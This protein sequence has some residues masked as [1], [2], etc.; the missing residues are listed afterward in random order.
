M[1]SLREA[2]FEVYLPIYRKL[3]LRHGN[4]VQIKAPLFP[5]YVFIKDHGR[6]A[7]PFSASRTTGVTS[8]AARTLDQSWVC[9]SV[10]QSLKANHDDEEV[11]CFDPTQVEP[12]KAVRVLVGPFAGFQGIFAEPDDRKRSVILLSLL[13]KSHRVSVSNRML[14]IAA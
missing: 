5:R 6:G 3:V 4:R 13:G 7:S 14:E 8:F 10:I 9:D 2:G 11:V 1:A 12:G